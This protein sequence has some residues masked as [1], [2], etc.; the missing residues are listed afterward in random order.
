MPGHG[1]LTKVFFESFGVWVTEYTIINLCIPDIKPNESFTN[2]NQNFKRTSCFFRDAKSGLITNIISS[3]LLHN[4]FLLPDRL[5]SW[6]PL[7]AACFLVK[8]GKMDTK[9]KRLELIPRLLTRPCEEKKMD[10]NKINIGRNFVIA[11]R[12][13]RSF[14][15]IFLSGALIILNSMHEI[16]QNIPVLIKSCVY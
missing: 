7:R 14:S 3:I 8:Q 4:I 6:G 13:L 16:A 11:C 5:S 12:L 10:Y 15:P 2:Q 9:D 1:I